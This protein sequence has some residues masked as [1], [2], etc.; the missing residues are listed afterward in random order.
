MQYSVVEMHH[1]IDDHSSKIQKY[2]LSIYFSTSHTVCL[3]RYPCVEKKKKKTL[4]LITSL[5][6]L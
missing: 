3:L 6:T 5:P 4:F 2:G 1:L